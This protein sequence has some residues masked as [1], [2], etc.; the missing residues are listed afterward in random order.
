[1]FMPNLRNEVRTTLRKGV[2]RCHI[3]LPESLS[4]VYCK[5]GIECLPF[6]L[7][8]GN[9]T[10]STVSSSVKSEFGVDQYISRRFEGSLEALWFNTL[11]KRY[12]G[13]LANV[14]V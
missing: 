8:A 1:M 4:R 11:F 3:F 14:I 5:V 7:S 6:L 12:F 13:Y 2:A 10:L 9:T